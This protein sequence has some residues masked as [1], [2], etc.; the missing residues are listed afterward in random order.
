MKYEFETVMDGVSN[1]INQELFSQMSDIQEFLARLVVGR[2][3]GNEESIKDALINN[4]FVRTFGIIDRDGMVDVDSLAKDL[5]REIGRKEKITFEL[6]VFGKM[7]F[8]P[9]D[10][11]VL[12]KSITG[13]EYQDQGVN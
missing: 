12:Y 11:D 9:E 4:G 10:V 8:H 2:F 5:K 7:T 1:Y 3:I 13:N 6:P